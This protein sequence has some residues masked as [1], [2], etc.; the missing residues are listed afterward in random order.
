LF[1]KQGVNNTTLNDI[2]NTTSGPELRRLGRNIKELDVTKWDANS[3]DVMKQLLKESFEQNPQASQRLLDTGNATLTHNQDKSKW[4]TE[5]PRLL[6]KVRDELRK[7]QSTTQP[8][9]STPTRTD[10]SEKSVTEQLVQHLEDSGFTVDGINKDDIERNEDYQFAIERPNAI[11]TETDDYEQ[12]LQTI[13]DKAPRN[14]EGRLLAPNDKPSNL[15][16]RLYAQVRT[17]EFKDWFGDW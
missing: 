1:A 13:L 7:S 11:S 3:S 17:K 8:Q 12:R 5:F 6:M 15:P 16:E 4:K 2:M 9:T 10:S 14:S